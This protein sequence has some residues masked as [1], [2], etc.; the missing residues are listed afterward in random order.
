MR[1]SLSSVPISSMRTI[2]K[3]VLG[4]MASIVSPGSHPLTK[5][6]QDAEYQIEC[7][8]EKLVKLGNSS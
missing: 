4:K 6:L 5:M 3:D 1:R 2:I 8:Q 7:R